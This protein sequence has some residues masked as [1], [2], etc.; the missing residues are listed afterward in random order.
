M[1]RHTS[2]DDL[3]WSPT[4][5]QLPVSPVTGGLPRPMAGNRCDEYSQQSKRLI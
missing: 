3:S 5:T 2:M 1:L 4:Q